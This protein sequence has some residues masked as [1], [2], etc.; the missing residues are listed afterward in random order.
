MNT[1]VWV[2]YGTGFIFLMTCLGAT[3]VF[4]FR[5]NTDE[6]VQK[7]FLGFA[8]GIMIA[9]SM[10]GLLVPSVNQAQSMGN[11]AWITV[12]VGFALG[13]VFLYILDKF[14]LFIHS[15]TNKKMSPGSKRTT[16][17]VS[18][19]T[20]H[21]IPEGMAVGIS[22][23]L[24]A[25]NLSEPTMYLSAIALAVG[26]GIQNFPEGAAVTLPLKREGMGS[27]KAFLLGCLSGA[28][29][30]LFGFAVVLAASAVSAIMPWLLAFAAGAMM[31]VVVE[32]L[33]PEAY[34]EGNS[35]L[36]TISVMAGFLLMMI[37]DIALG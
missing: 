16:L 18:A 28:V 35:R 6:K 3:T 24:A 32:E 25:Q 20:L 29:E 14:V 12:S 7:I 17:L 4:C 34:M 37:L 13:I 22:F 27:V 26:I 23:A 36:G 8:S 15:V 1:F 31:Y 33:L 21:N 9:A 19:V 30:P 11:I 10:F 2:A 5:K